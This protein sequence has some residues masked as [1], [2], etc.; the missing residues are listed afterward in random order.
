MTSRPE[1]ERNSRQVVGVLALALFGVLAAVFLT[2]G[3]GD[4]AG[5]PG[6]GSITAAI[7]YAMFNFDA[8]AFPS[9]GFLVSFIVIA[10][11][12]DAALDVAVMLGLQEEDGDDGVA[13][14]GRGGDR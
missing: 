12:L 11:V 14:D 7:G 4:A 9:E 8:G 5:F 13:A 3:F 10:V 6:E 2:A 1:L